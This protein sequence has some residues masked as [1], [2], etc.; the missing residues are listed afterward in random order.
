MA[1]RHFFPSFFLL[2]PEVCLNAW[3]VLRNKIISNLPLVSAFPRKCLVAFPIL[4]LYPVYWNHVLPNGVC[5]RTGQE[6]FSPTGKM[7]RAFEILFWKLWKEIKNL[8]SLEKKNFDEWHIKSVVSI[9]WGHFFRFYFFPIFTKNH[10]IDKK[11]KKYI[12]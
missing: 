7:F 11:R 10:L 8:K 9:F 4:P 1:K 5:S 2:R 12:F 6:V 3:A